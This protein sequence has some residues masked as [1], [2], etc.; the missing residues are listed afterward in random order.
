MSLTSPVAAQYASSNY[1]TNEVFFGNGGA[2]NVCSS[3]YCSQQSI[4]E[5][6]VGN[7]SSA[8]YQA[9][10]GF[11][12]TD[13]PVL[14]LNVSGGVFNLGLVDSSAAKYT[15]TTFSVRSYLSSGYIV[16]LVGTS[17]VNGFNGH[18]ITGLT[19]PTISQPGVEQFGVNLR[20][21]TTPPVG[22]DPQQLP[23]SSFSFGAPATDY[24][25]VNK[26]KFVNGDTIA[27]STSSSGDTLYTLSAILNVSNSTPAGVYGDLGGLYGGSLYIIV[28]PTF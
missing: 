1:Q 7:S 28:V 17:P 15:S 18:A 12:T 13:A 5:I 3:S 6:G 4:G 24:N 10:S 14:E 27:Q 26:Y 22:A 21:N 11:N 2:L 19:T 23:D 8:N 9:N 20:A 25:I 16:K